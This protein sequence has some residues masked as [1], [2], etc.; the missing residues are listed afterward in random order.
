[1]SSSSS[2][3]ALRARLAKA[4]AGEAGPLV[5][6]GVYDG[7]STRVAHDVGFEALYMTGKLPPLSLPSLQRRRQQKDGRRTA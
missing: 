7:I 1:M 6:P 3:Q 4:V 2:A 5:A